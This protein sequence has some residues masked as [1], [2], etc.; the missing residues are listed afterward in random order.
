MEEPAITLNAQQASNVLR[1]S[2]LWF[3]LAGA[4]ISLGL[5]LWTG[6]RNSS[7]VLP[8][9]FMVWVASPFAGLIWFHRLAKSW[10]AA[11]QFDLYALMHVVSVG[12]VV[13]YAT[14]V[15]LMHLTRQAGPFL[16]VPAASWLIIIFGLSISRYFRR[17]E[18]TK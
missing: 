7:L 2:A 13:A 16:A 12:S 1:R 10:A 14:A 18:A 4:A 9:M 6:R 17:K 11:R 15:F 8:L 3:A 5:T